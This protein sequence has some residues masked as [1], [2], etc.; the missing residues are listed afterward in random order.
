MSD[1]P[2]TDLRAAVIG[3]GMMGRHHVRIL[4]AMKGVELVAVVDADLDRATSF[5]EAHG[6]RAFATVDEVP[7]VDIAVVAVP[8]EA[9]VPVAEMLMTR[10]VSLL[11]EK[12]LAGTH[13]E[14]ERLVAAA[15]AAGVT[16]AVGHVERFNP[17][18]RFLAS[19][20]LEPRFMQFERLSPF[21][22]RITTSVVSDLMIH[23]LDLACFLAGEDPVRVEA[24]GT[25]VFSEAAD[26][27]AALLEFPSGCVASISASRATQDKVRRIS[28]TESERFIL[29]DCLRQD[30]SVKRETTVEFPSSEPNL[31]RQAN[32]VEIPYLDRGGEPLA[33]EL[34]DFVGA[35][36]DRRPPQVTG[37][38]GLRAV[39]L[40]EA[41]ERAT[42]APGA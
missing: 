35:V 42:G 23:D 41:V 4:G 11:I 25:A 39:E 12:P 17:V 5:A 37:A 24:V 20:P 16:L 38:D 40:A 15:E 32:V 30:V 29:A 28:V 8:T 3:A 27:A 34:T 31:Y 14:A 21:T 7:D 22:P 1:R 13:E 10:G 18:V 19:M 33:L 6:A 2:T 36:R 9:H 26:I